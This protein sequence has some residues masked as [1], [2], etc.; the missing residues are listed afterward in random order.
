M[1]ERQSVQWVVAWSVAWLALESAPESPWAFAAM[2]LVL[3][4]MGIELLCL[5]AALVLPWRGG[6]AD[7]Q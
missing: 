4:G 2:L 5:V 6:S 7:G 3:A 1:A